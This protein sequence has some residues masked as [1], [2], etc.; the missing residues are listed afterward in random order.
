MPIS[1]LEVSTLGL[2]DDARF[3]GRSLL[4]L[5]RH[6]EYFEKLDDTLLIPFVRDAQRAA[7]AI[8]SATG[9]PRVNFAILG[10]AE[11]HIHWHL[12]PRNPDREQRPGRSPWDDPREKAPLPKASRDEIVLHIRLALERIARETSTTE[13]P[14][15]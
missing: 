15:P 4:V 1:E 2:Y 5:N 14:G 12:I 8:R 11:P 10:N 3:P 7:D 13:A 9:S 6:F